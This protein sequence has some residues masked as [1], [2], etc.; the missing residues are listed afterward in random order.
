[1]GRTTQR[2]RGLVVGLATAA[3]CVA[4]FA[5][6]APSASAAPGDF[7]ATLHDTTH[8]FQGGA[9]GSA[10]CDSADSTFVLT[11]TGVSVHDPEFPLHGQVYAEIGG[12]TPPTPFPGDITG[13]GDT[14]QLTH[15]F[16][17]MC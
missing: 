4:G 7:T 9:S 3:L 6:L 11:V 10:S 2:H 1:M 15:T 13:P 17:G 12:V 5:G 16:A 14:L 8:S